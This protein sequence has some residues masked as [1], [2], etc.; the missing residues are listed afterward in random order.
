M[1]E[2]TIINLKKYN[3]RYG[4]VQGDEILQF[5]A[6]TITKFF[7]KKSCYR[8]SNAHFIVLCPDIT[9]ENFIHI[10]D[11]FYQEL[12]EFYDQWI[13][14]EKVWEKNSLV[15]ETMQEQKIHSKLAKSD[16]SIAKILERLNTAFVNGKFLT[17]LQ[18][19]AHTKTNQICGAEA[20]IRYNDP[21]KGIIPPG[22]FLPEIERA[23]LKLKVLKD[24]SCDVIQGYYLNK[25]LSEDD[26]KKI[27][28]ITNPH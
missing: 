20:L 28:G 6:Q 3:Q 1:I 5:I 22:R 19:K 15:L 23:G 24:L 14:C 8:I 16:Q 18:P 2:I 12:I 26:F 13:I 4:I 17:F 9:Y 10:Y 11:T 25:P 27:S 7:D 21:Q